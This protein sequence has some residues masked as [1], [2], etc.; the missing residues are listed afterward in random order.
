MKPSLEILVGGAT[1]AVGIL[2]ALFMEP[3]AYQTARQVAS[4]LGDSH[5]FASAKSAAPF[6]F[7]G[8]IIGYGVNGIRQ[9]LRRIARGE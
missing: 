6:A 9:G 5:Y 4:Q 8:L 1:V 2:T 3:T 7:Y